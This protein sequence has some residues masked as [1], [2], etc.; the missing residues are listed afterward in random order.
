MPVTEYRRRGSLSQQDEVLWRAHPDR[1]E[2][3]G[4]DGAVERT[5]LFR[6]IQR[7]RLASA[8]RRT[9]PSRFLMELGAARTR[10]VLS[11]THFE[12][13]GDDQIDL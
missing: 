13:S 6:N 3:I 9:Q 5:V 2:Q 7:V 10:H 1:L 11:N 8:P 4:A 12:E